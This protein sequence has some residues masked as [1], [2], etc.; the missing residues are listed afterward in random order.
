MTLEKAI[1][2][3]PYDPAT[4]SRSAYARYLRYTVDGL[5]EK[6]LAE[7]KK[8]WREYERFHSRDGGHEDPVL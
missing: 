3:N 2:M 7:V 8:I 5:Y 4:G 1:Q 6:S